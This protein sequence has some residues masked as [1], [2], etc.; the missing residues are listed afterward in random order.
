MRRMLLRR[1]GGGVPGNCDKSEIQAKAILTSFVR[2]STRDV[3]RDQCR[4]RTRPFIPHRIAEPRPLEHLCFGIWS[5][6]RFERNIPCSS[7]ERTKSVNGNNMVLTKVYI[8]RQNKKV[9][10]QKT[11]LEMNIL[12]VRGKK[13]HV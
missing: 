11:K 3:G 7:L 6:S 13:R 5:A 2:D 10:S 4:H 8:Y 12:L 9:C 1:N